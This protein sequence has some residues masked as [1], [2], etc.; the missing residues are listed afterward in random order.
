MIAIIAV[1]LITAVSVGADLRP[2]DVFNSHMVLQR[3]VKLP[4]WGTA[5]PDEKISV[6]LKGQ[7]VST[8]ADKRGRWEVTLAPEPH[9]GPFSLVIEGNSSVIFSDILIGD[10]WIF[11]GQSNA[12]WGTGT[13]ELLPLAEVLMAKTSRVRHGRLADLSRTAE[14]PQERL[15]GRV[16]WSV[17][18]PKRSY[19]LPVFFLYPISLATGIPQGY[20]LTARA[21]T[22][23]EPWIA[24]EGYD[25][26]DGLDES[27]EKLAILR[28]GTARYKAHSEKQ[29]D[30]IRH[31]LEVAKIRDQHDEPVPALDIPPRVPPAVRH[32]YPTCLYN[33]S[34][35]PLEP[36][37]IRG[38]FWYQGESN[39][40]DP[41]YQRKLTAFTSAIRRNFRSPD[42][43][44]FIVQ[45]CPCEWYGTDNTRLPELWEQ[46]LAFADADGR[47]W[48]AATGDIGDVKDLHPGGRS[49]EYIAR[50]LSNLALRHLY[51]RQDIQ[52]DFPRFSAL[53][54]QNDALIVHFDHVET[55]SSTDGGPILHFEVAGA[56]GRHH[57]AN[58]RID[59]NRIVVQSDVV[60][61]P[62][63]VRYGWSNV[64]EPNLHNEAG[65]PPYAFR[66][67]SGAGE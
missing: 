6:S 34:F 36:M 43:G 5:T 54:R 1:L 2:A 58:A 57:P 12:P 20:V 15:G 9:G 25:A 16:D 22:S 19:A 27:Q 35:S 47:S 4:V 37:A 11:S 41:D 52:A 3:D 53:E 33:G 30:Y 8:V 29:F 14:Y 63:H 32:H 60:R 18:D 7:R 55:F 59:G 17:G 61:D 50:R 62:V 49:K 24:M 10:V 67:G 44:F 13:P 21:G 39:A 56:D 28:P 65:L 38:V 31:W 46:Q 42:A 26:V 51:G 66:T 45:P 64:A 48:V 40:G 23:I